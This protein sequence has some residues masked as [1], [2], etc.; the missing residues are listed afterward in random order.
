VHPLRLATFDPRWKW[1][2]V[3]P[4]SEFS[5]PAYSDLAAHPGLG[6][7]MRMWLAAASAVSESQCRR[8]QQ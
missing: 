5:W 4:G 1:L 2:E 8:I 6:F 3:A 7:A